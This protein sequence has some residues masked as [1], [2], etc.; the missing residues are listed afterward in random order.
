MNKSERKSPIRSEEQ[1]PL[2]RPTH[3]SNNAKV[4]NRQGF[5]ESFKGKV[6][7]EQIVKEIPNPKMQNKTNF[8]QSQVKS[9]ELPLNKHV[10]VGFN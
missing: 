10:Q 7:K 2:R 3:N 5:D 4:N 9:S 8:K 6:N 1:K